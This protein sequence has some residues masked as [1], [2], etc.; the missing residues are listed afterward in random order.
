MCEPSIAGRRSARNK[1]AIRPGSALPMC[2]RRIAGDR[3][4]RPRISIWPT[5]LR[6]ALSN[7]SSSI[8]GMDISSPS[9]TCRVATYYMVVAGTNSLITDQANRLPVW[10]HRGLRQR[11]QP[12]QQPKLWLAPGEWSHPHLHLRREQQSRHRGHT[13]QPEPDCLAIR[14]PKAQLAGAA[15]S[16]AVRC[17]RP[18]QATARLTNYDT[19]LRLKKW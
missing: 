5:S 17:F 8:R 13:R 3:V 16:T 7:P 1:T 15:I 19:V 6:R 14:Q 9:S 10:H 12:A 11:S 18:R 4:P 2:R